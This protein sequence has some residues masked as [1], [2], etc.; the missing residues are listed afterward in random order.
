MDFT[1]LTLGCWI[2]IV[3]GHTSSQSKAIIGV[4]KLALCA[5]LLVV[6]VSISRN[7][8]YFWPINPKNLIS[9]FLQPLVPS[10]VCSSSGFCYHKDFLWPLWFSKTLELAFLF[11]SRLKYKGY[12]FGTCW[13]SHTWHFAFQMEL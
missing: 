3:S 5:L 2:P 1:L 13:H 8:Q 11:T 7:S 12:Q 10:L 9:K 4:R 6:K